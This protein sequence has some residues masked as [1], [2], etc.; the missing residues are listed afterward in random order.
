MK[1]SCKLCKHPSRRE[2][3][4]TTRGPGLRQHR[5][6]PG[7]TKDVGTRGNARTKQRTQQPSQTRRRPYSRRR[8]CLH[9]NTHDRLRRTTQA[10]TGRQRTNNNVADNTAPND[11]NQARIRQTTA[12]RNRQNAKRWQYD[13]KVTGTRIREAE[14]EVRVAAAEGN[15]E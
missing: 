12:L 13:E 11:R 10:E 6:R 4:K 3:K 9:S 7:K 15:I 8:S 5:S 2:P 1:H 14:K